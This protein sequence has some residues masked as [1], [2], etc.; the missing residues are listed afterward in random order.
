MMSYVNNDVEGAK[1]SPFSSPNHT[2]NGS[3]AEDLGTLH[4]DDVMFPLV[5]ASVSALRTSNKIREITEGLERKRAGEANKGGKEVISLSIGDPTKFGNL[6]PSEKATQAVVEAVLS[7]KANG[8]A[9]STVRIEQA[10]FQMAE[11]P[12]TVQLEISKLAP[13]CS[14]IWFVGSGD[15]EKGCCRE[16]LGAKRRRFAEFTRYHLNKRVLPRHSNVCHCSCGPDKR[17]QRPHS[18]TWL[19]T[20]QNYLRCAESPHQLRNHIAFFEMAALTFP[21]LLGLL[22]AQ[23]TSASK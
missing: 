2:P 18:P 13:K 15:V 4:E 19:F 5:S 21:G 14:A 20:V 10:H 1:F 3:H 23:I 9:P 22:S 16:V 8:Y 6:Q 7:G 12:E 17:P 11:R